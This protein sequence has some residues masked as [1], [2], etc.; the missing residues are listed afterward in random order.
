MKQERSIGFK[1][2]PINVTLL[3]FKN[4]GLIIGNRCLIKIKFRCFPISIFDYQRT[5]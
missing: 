5:F 2:D 4:D 1:T 3:F